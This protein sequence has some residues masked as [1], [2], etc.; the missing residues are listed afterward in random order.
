MSAK[1]SWCEQMVE[2]MH[3]TVIYWGEGTKTDEGKQ[4]GLCRACDVVDMTEG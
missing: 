1:N 2:T 3:Y 4:M